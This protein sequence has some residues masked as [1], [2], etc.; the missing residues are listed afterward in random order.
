MSQEQQT[1]DIEEEQRHSAL[2]PSVAAAGTTAETDLSGDPAARISELEAENKRL[3]EA[4]F[5]AHRRRYRFTAI[6]LAAIGLLAF[7]GAVLFPDQRTVLLALG[8]TGVFGAVLTYFLTPERFVSAAVGERIY[9]TLADNEAAIINDLELNGEPTVVPTS[10]HAGP[11][12]L[13]VSVSPETLPSDSQELGIPFVTGETPGLALEPTGVGL[14]EELTASATALPNLPPA[15]ARAVGDALVEQFE[16]IDGVDIEAGDGR[17]TMAIEGS[18]YGPV[19]Q[20]DHPI[21]SL[22]ATTLAVELQTPV[23][24]SVTKADRAD[25]L[26]TCRFDR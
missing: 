23:M 7:G 21:G 26:V 17:I 16:L 12:R 5:A 14:Y 1:D 10:G 9:G 4:V 24:I 20:F 19:D 8:G 13:F 2:D 3:R 11:A 15:L 6:G 25:W 18:A 22:L